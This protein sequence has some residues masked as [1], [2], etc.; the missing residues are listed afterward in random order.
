MI[1]NFGKKLTVVVPI[2]LLLVGCSVTDVGPTEGQLSMTYKY[3]P[4]EV[5]ASKMAYGPA[6]MNQQGVDSI[7]VSRTRFVLRDV[8]YKSQSDSGN[9]KAD[10]FVL[11]LNLTGQMQELSSAK[12]PFNTYRRIEFDVHRMEQSDVNK[13]P[14]ADQPAFQ[15]FLAGDRYSIIV[16]G[17]VYKSGLAPQSFTFRSRVSA[18]QKTDLTPELVVNA[19]NPVA[20]VTMVVTSAG[21]FK[22]SSGALLDPTDQANE[23]AISDNLKASIRVFK[24]N[25]KD[26]SKD[27]N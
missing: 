4:L 13:L 12:V 20:N 23:N 16:S 11:E 17:T 14:A 26:G 10:P 7:R 21:W 19:S 6:T 1:R 25:N 18:K 3:T 27:S 24:D 2:L 22:S 5:S 8:K 15:D 9:F